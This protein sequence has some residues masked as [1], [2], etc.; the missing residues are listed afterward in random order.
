[1]EERETRP[2][3]GGSEKAHTGKNNH[4]LQR[5]AC[6]EPKNISSMQERSM[7]TNRYVDFKGGSSLSFLFECRV[8]R[9]GGEAWPFKFPTLGQQGEGLTG[10]GW[11]TG[12]CE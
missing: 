8:L 3:L 11:S 9:R 6:R 10:W 7:E 2:K 12:K 1:M 4:E 5:D